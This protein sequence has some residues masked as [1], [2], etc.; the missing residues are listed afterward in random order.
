MT[1]EKKAMVKAPDNPVTALVQRFDRER[2]NV[3]AP[4]THM[5]GLPIGTRLSVTEISI[6]PD[7][8]AKEVFPIAG[9]GKMPSKVSLDR[10]AN[11]AGIS[12]LDE[13]RQDNG[14]HPHYC[15]ML[16]RGRIT[17]FDGTV[18]EITGV[19]AVDLRED[20][21]GEEMGKDFAE[22]TTK[23]K[24]GSRDPSQQ[25][26][27]ARKFIQEIAAS[28]AKNRAIASALGIKRSYTDEELR[29]PFIVPKL[30]L[31]TNNPI[32][33]AAVMANMM[34]ATKAMFGARSNVIDANFTESTP[35]ALPPA[36][37]EDEK[38]DGGD[39]PSSSPPD[40][41][42][43]DE[44]A[45]PEPAPTGGPEVERYVRDAWGEAKKAGMKPEAFRELCKSVTG[46]QSKIEMSIDDA[47][48]V[49][50]AVM[51][52]VANATEGVPV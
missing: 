16:V 18:R 43:D 11:A 41:P 45:S 7:P 9:G 15:E 50:R 46:K 38:S 1:N 26:M 44:K 31:D 6:N 8:A 36:T 35:A 10:I 29:R 51:A 2:Y 17:D 14:K 23:A 28:K 21:G 30:T 37:E 22:I 3:L 12:W 52:F 39:S 42:V 24:K 4:K 5:D 33:Q 34:G 25:L 20:A 47:K 32:A 13:R 40:D 48:T 27:E 19:K 49:G